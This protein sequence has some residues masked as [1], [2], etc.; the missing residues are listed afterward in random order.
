[1]I[2]FSGVEEMGANFKAFLPKRKGG[3]KNKNN[4]VPLIHL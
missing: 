3:K 2:N 1:V 4:K